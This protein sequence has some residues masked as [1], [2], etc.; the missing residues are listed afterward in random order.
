MVTVAAGLRVGSRDAR[1]K[2]VRPIR[3]VHARNTREVAA[4]ADRRSASV[5]AIETD[6]EEFVAGQER[7]LER[8]EFA[9]GAEQ[10]VEIRLLDVQAGRSGSV[11]VF[12]D[13]VVS[14]CGVGHSRYSQ[15]GD[16][17]RGP[18]MGRPA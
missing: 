8:I 4:V 13:Y 18:D 6:L 14:T 1:R 16:C 9:N 5:H 11:H 12:D 15:S 17:K 2:H 3:E 10:D 7:K